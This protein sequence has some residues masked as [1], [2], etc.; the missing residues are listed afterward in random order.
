MVR[1]I[2]QD[3]GIGVYIE[4]LVDELLR[5]TPDAKFLLLFRSKKRMGRF[6]HFP[7]AE[8][9]LL[10]APHKLLWDQWAVPWCAWRWRADVIFNPKFS[11]P[12]ISHC[13]VA[14]GLQ[15]PAWWRWP[16]FYEWWDVLYMKTMLPLYCHKAKHI[17]PFS[18]FVVEE[19]RKYFNLRSDRITVTHPAPTEHFH[20]I[21]DKAALARFRAEQDLPERFV[22]AVT[23]VSHTGHD[24]P[25]WFPGKNIETV[26]H[27]FALVRDA[28]PHELVVAGGVVREYLLATGWEESDLKR[29]RFLGLVPHA[30]MPPLY[31]AAEM[32]VLPSL[33]ESYSFPLA[34]A[35]ACGCPVITSDTSACPETTAGAALLADP[36][37]PRKFAEHILSVASDEQL[38]MELRDKGLQRSA[39][40][41]WERTGRLTMSGLVSAVASR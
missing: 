14:M 34:E 5:Q 23:R 24:N 4:Y 7:N 27:A 25:T 41:S 40:F 37:N 35:M 36:L 20:R 19:N 15:E 30:N 32:F 8:E 39:D 12:L 1:A 6:S 2:D 26:L 11:V 10:R 9:V 16:Q 22:L 17:F 3:D 21:S 13:P 29:V 18:N 31:S 33:Y 38:R 28:I